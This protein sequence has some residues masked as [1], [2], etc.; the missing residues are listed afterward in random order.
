MNALLTTIFPYFCILSLASIAIIFTERDG[1]I[2][3]RV[4]GVM[5]FGATTYMI[6]AHII[7]PGSG[8]QQSPWLNIVLYG[9]AAIGGILFSMLHGF[10]SIKLKGNQIISGIALNILA[11]AFTLIVLYLFG[12]AN[13]MPYNVGRLELG[14]SANNE[15]IS[16]FSLKMFVTILAIIISFVLLSFTKWGLRF[17]SVGENPQAADSAGINVDSIKWKAII[18]SGVLAGLAGAIYISE[19]SSGSAF[20]SQVTVEG[21]G[22]LAIAIVLISR[23]KTLLSS[24]ISIIFALLF[25]LGQQATNLFSNGSS[26]QPILMMLPYLLTLVIM[27]LFSKPVA[28]FLTKL[29]KKMAKTSEAPKALGQPYDK[30]KR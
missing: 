8:P 21:L 16:F 30:S 4:N 23:W 18:I 7:A 10:I 22:F 3:L 20:K 19:F 29:I 12:E 28:K 2:N 5:V 24:L 17:K 25:A 1:I 26:I 27:I 15:V 11:P 13:S 9:F 14:N 6:F